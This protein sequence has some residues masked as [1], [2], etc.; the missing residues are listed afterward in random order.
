MTDFLVF[1]D[2]IR[3]N[4]QPFIDA[5]VDAGVLE[6]FW[7]ALEGH[8]W[9]ELAKPKHTHEWAFYEY[10]WT[11]RKIIWWCSCK[12]TLTTSSYLPIEVP[13]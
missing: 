5:L 10:D 7:S 9:Y 2:S 1:I 13:E 4:P 3:R 12:E 11:Q 6:K 8:W